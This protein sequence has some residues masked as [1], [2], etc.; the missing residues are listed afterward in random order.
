[1]FTP[2]RYQLSDVRRALIDNSQNLD[3]GELLIPGV[4][5]ATPVV[6]TGGGTTGL[7][8]GAVLGI[9]GAGGKVLELNSKAVASDNV[10]NAQIAASYVPLYM[11]QEHKTELDAAAGTTTGSG[12]FGNFAV[13]STGLLASEAS[14]VVFSTRSAVQMFSL[15][16]TNNTAKPKEITVVFFATVGGAQS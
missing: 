3:K 10:T 11:V 8:L 7:L 13:D 1:M 15:G 2:V 6:K 5:S 14:Y 4:T 16:L 12:A 9:E